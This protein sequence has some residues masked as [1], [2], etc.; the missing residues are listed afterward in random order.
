MLFDLN[1]QRCGYVPYVAVAIPI[2][3]T[4]RFLML[5]HQNHKKVIAK[6]TA[7]SSKSLTKLVCH[8]HEFFYLCIY[9]FG[10]HQPQVM[11]VLLLPW[12]LCNPSKT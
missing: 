11:V 4:E 7:H 2:Q 6:D 12:N 10:L 3:A 5:Q 9:I 8:F 1:L